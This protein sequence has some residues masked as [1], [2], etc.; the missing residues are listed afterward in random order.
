MDQ[1]GKPESVKESG[2]LTRPQPPEP[3]A[4]TRN[5]VAPTPVVRTPS[6][7]PANNAAQPA[8]HPAPRA[9]LAT[10]AVDTP[11]PV[12][13]AAMAHAFL[14]ADP[15]KNIGPP[16]QVAEIAVGIHPISLWDPERQA[17]HPIPLAETGKLKVLPVEQANPD[18]SQP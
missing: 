16:I 9:R 10:P 14:F 15:G 18:P 4:V 12:E 5:P 17:V 11:Q 7:S 13:I 1:S 8:D 2:L 6:P 3:K